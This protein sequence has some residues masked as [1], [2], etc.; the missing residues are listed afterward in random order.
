[1]YG[2]GT[3][4]VPTSTGSYLEAFVV[5][6][7]DGPESLVEEGLAEGVEPGAEDAALGH[8]V[9]GEVLQD[10]LQRHLWQTLQAQHTHTHSLSNV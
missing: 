1:M 10:V 6:L 3:G 5:V 7:F 2:T 9:I 4:T 8:L